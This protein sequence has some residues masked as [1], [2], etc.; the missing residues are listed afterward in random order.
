ML[1]KK[2]RKYVYIQKA[3]Y[4]LAKKN[5]IWQANITLYVF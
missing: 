1:I 4:M 5:I 3:N 2:N